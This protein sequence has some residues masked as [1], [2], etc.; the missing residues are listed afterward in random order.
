MRPQQRHVGAA[1]VEGD[2]LP[3]HALLQHHRAA[4]GADML[5]HQGVRRVHGH[6]AQ[7]LRLGVVRHL[8]TQRIFG[9]EHGGVLGRLDD[10]ALDPRHGLH[11]VHAAQTEMIRL[12]VE[13]SAHVAALVAH[14]AAQQPAARRLQDG[15]IHR[16]VA[17]DHARRERPGHVAAD[18]LVAVDVDAVGGGQAGVMPGKL[19]QMRQHA[20]RGGLAVGAGDGGHRDAALRPRREQHVHDLARHV[21]RLAL[22]GRHVHAKA[23]GGIDLAD[24]TAHFL[25]GLGDVVG[26]EVHAGHIQPNGLGGAHSHL[27]V[28]RV[29]HVGLVDGRAA[30]GQVAGGAQEDTLAL[31]RDA[32]APVAHLLQQPLGLMVDLDARQHLLVPDAA[33]GVLVDLLHQLRAGVL[34]VAHHVPGQALR[35]RHQLAV[36]HQH[37]MVEALDVA[38][39]DDATTVLA[40][41]LVGDVHV[42]GVVQ[43][44]GHTAPMVGVERLDHHRVTDALRH[45][46]GVL[47]VVR[48]ALLGHRKT[49]IGEDAVGLLLVGGDLHADVPGLAGHRGLDALLEAAMTELHQAVLVQ[50]EERDLAVARRLDQRRGAGPQ[51]AALCEADETITLGFEV[52][53]VRHRPGSADL[54]GQ[55]RLE[56][57]QRQAAGLQAHLGLLVAVDHV[58]APRLARGPRLAEGDLGAGNALDL[59]G[60]VL[61]HMSEPGAVIL[62]QPPHEPAGLAIR[63]AVRPET[64][65]GIQKRIHEL[66]AQAAGGPFLQDPQVH[67]EADHAEQG[68]EAGTHIHRGLEDLHGAIPFGCPPP[69]SGWQC[70][71]PGQSCRHPPARARAAR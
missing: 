44:D 55:Q 1:V 33:A 7:V 42:V 58:V 31:G 65:Q 40:R 6:V 2:V 23:R 15:H 41:L 28:V 16:G 18:R 43:L 20:C 48:Q 60:A 14:A 71:S 67:G 57:L 45:L 52:E 21:P 68:V 51:D 38:L 37:A 34:A 66:R 26:E 32:V 3:A 63:T 64:G 9:V 56:Q 24:G 8:E 39:H 70:G 46:D 54:P 69:T 62:A 30:G 10:D 49:Q 25:V 35:H 36:H 11:G 50:A 22:A 59:D 53:I 5:L 12:D 27:A 61:Q 29:D 17:Q 19:E 13:D 47:R 4:A